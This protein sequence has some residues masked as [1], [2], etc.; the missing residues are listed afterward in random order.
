MPN[1][2]VDDIKRL[3]ELTGSG[4]LDTKNALQEADGDFDKA[5]EILRL[6]GAKDVNK[7]QTR[8]TA[9]GLVAAV[10][11]GTASGVLLELNCETDFVAKTERFEQLGQELA[12]HI[13]VAQPADVAELLASELS[14]RPVQD[15]VDETSATLGEKLV[16]TRFAAL[17][18][19]GG[20]VATYLHRTNPDLP[21]QVGV[22][23]ELDIEDAEL[24]K[25]VAQHIAAM[26][27]AYL[28]RDEVPAE[29]VEKE[30]RLAEQ[31]ARDEGKPDQA[32]PK[33]VEGRVNAYYK[34]VVLL[35]QVFV[36][37]GKKTI[38]ALLAEKG[39]QVRRFARFR[40]GQS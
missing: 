6:K 9:N 1:F 22:L 15:I 40:V 25:N 37:D 4:M 28:H 11:D 38:A 32:V 13:A 3:R 26:A 20:Y 7:R 14:G 34:D 2:T 33:I 10:L 5:T 16:V 12:A 24:A 27:P 39:A 31:M 35:D 19:D 23:I 17:G 18:D 8:T 30:R 21:P 36:K 29:V